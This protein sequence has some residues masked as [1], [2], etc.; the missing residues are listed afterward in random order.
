MLSLTQN[1]NLH[2]T[3]DPPNMRFLQIG[4]LNK[5]KITAFEQNAVGASFYIFY[6]RKNRWAN[7]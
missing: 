4:Q 1:V 7:F 3:F 6:L 5:S 2:N